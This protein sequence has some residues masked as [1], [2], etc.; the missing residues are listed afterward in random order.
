MDIKIPKDENL[1]NVYC[2]ICYMGFSTVEWIVRHYDY[3]DSDIHDEC[4]EKSGP[5]STVSP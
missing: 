2:T 4:C 3:D 5:C 1:L